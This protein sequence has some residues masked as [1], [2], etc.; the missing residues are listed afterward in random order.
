MMYV[1]TFH[2]VYWAITFNI[3]LVNL[4]LEFWASDS[5]VDDT[6]TISC[7]EGMSSVITEL[8]K[9]AKKDLRSQKNY[10]MKANPIKSQVFT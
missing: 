4:F 6:T 3:D 7:A 2:D 5:Y 10:Y 9:I 8:H 1:R